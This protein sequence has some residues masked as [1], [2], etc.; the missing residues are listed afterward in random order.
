VLITSCTP[1]LQHPGFQFEASKIHRG[2]PLKE[3]GPEDALNFFQSMMKLPPTPT[4]PRL[5]DREALLQL[6]SL[7]D[8]HPLSIALLA[9]QLKARRPAELGERLE[10]LLTEGEN[11]KD[12]SLVASLKLSL[13]RPDSEARRLLPRLGIFQGGAWEYPFYPWASSKL[14]VLMLRTPRFFACK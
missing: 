11:D 13:D 14:V 3:L 8:F 12:K 10:A 2:L 5:P 6:F 4:V 1:D 9:Q 7:V